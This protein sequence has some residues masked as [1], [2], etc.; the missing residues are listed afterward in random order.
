MPYY[1]P[2]NYTNGVEH[3]GFT[4]KPFDEVLNFTITK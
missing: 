4:E 2:V 3:F 1:L